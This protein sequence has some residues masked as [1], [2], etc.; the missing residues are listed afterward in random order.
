MLHISRITLITQLHQ[1]PKS[2]AFLNKS[3][4]VFFS[5][6]QISY[7][8]MYEVVARKIHPL[9]VNNLLTEKFNSRRN[10]EKIIIIN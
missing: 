5:N 8:M 7:T 9:S 6:T 3:A 2:T 4:D 10:N 1:L